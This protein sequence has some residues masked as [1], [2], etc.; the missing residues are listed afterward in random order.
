MLIQ[1]YQQIQLQ[2]CIISDLKSQHEL[3]LKK[4]DELQSAI[5][6]KAH[7]VQTLQDT[8]KSNAQKIDTLQTTVE[9]HL[10]T[11]ARQAEAQRKLE[12]QI[13]Q[14]LR[15]LYGRKSER[16]ID[17]G[18]LTLFD[19]DDLKALCQEAVEDE[20]EAKKPRHKRRGHGRRP[21]PDHL[22]REVIRHEVAEPERNCP[23]CG[24]VRI[25]IGHDKSEQ[26]EYTPASFK[27]L[28][29]H[30][31]KY[32]CRKCQEQVCQA[33]APPKPIEKGLPGPGLL[34]HVVLAKYGDHQPLYRLEDIAA[35]ICD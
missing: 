17:P 33:P 22:P 30:R 6:L 15:R 5:E 31:V 10:Q 1:Q 34:S 32:A 29:H 23:C 21:L 19:A 26:L 7:A 25:E 9:L 28:E 13:E 3:E 27:V 4:N 8:I 14:I 24:E 11:I 18:Q 35:R 2:I 20:Q 12:H 16:F